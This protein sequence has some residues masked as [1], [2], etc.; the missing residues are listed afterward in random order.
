[1]LK[2]ALLLVAAVLLILLARPVYYIG[3]E[4][5]L[6]QPLTRPRGVSSRAHSVSV[7]K[8]GQVWFD[9]FVDHAKDVD[10]CRAWDES[11]R[12]IAYGNYRLD[13]EHRAATSAELKP[14]TVQPYPGHPELAWIHLFGE[15]GTFSKTLVPVNSA[16]E[17]LERFE[18]H[19]GGE[20]R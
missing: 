18:V 1:M 7:F 13:G 19:V 2:R 8:M 14:S 17:P 3:V 10:V 5:N 9:C 12:L 4:F 15:K 20:K 6:W 16:G 11:G